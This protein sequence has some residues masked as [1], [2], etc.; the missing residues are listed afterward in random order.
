MIQP[1]SSDVKDQVWAPFSVDFHS[2]C[3]YN[4]VNP[5]KNNTCLLILATNKFNDSSSQIVI[6]YLSY[7]LN[8]A[9]I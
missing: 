6:L 5:F 8:G 1:Y 2:H 3:Y 4:L 7:L 9:Q